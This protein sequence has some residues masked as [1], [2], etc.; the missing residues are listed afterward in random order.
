MESR[1]GAAHSE[2][3]PS[4]LAKMTRPP[5]IVDAIPLKGLR[6]RLTFSDGLVR[7]L[8]FDP[9]LKDGVLEDLRDPAVFREVRSTRWPERLPGRMGWTWIP[10]SSTGTT[11]QPVSRAPPCSGSTASK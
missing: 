1:L 4:R 7:E 10:M 3:P 6:L 11:C 8:D 2:Q 5:R 9:V